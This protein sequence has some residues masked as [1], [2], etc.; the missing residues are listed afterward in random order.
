MDL[1]TLHP[2][3]IVRSSRAEA[4]DDGWDGVAASIALDPNR[5][6]PEALLG[7]D[8][9]SHIEVVYYFHAPA[10]KREEVGAR[11]PR[12][13][14]DWPLVGIFAQRAK[15]RPNRLGVTTCRLLAVEGLSIR[16]HGLDAIEG[17]PVLDI[18]PYMSGFAPRGP[19]REPSWAKE[20]MAH[21]W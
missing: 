19:L 6:G 4:T 13:R 21:Y 7:L 17:S 3:G 15:D 20:L 9:F 14:P 2:I 8:A 1:V 18:K 11:R 5:F 10:D 16:V 12:G